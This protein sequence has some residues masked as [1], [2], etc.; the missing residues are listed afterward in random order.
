MATVDEVDTTSAVK[1]FLERDTVVSRTEED[2]D[3]GEEVTAI[4]EAAA[5]SFLL[6]PQSALT[7]VLMAKNQLQQIVSKDIELLDFIDRAINDVDNPDIQISDL[8]DL[9]EASTALV[10]I[11]RI[12]SFQSDTKAFTRYND[13]INR[14]LDQQLA[15]SLKRR[16]RGEFERSGLEARQDLSNGL[17]LFGSTHEVLIEVLTNLVSS[18]DNFRSVDLTKLVSQKTV[19]RV[20]TS[21]QKVQ[22]GFQKNSIS[23]TSAA[24]ELMAGAASLQSISKERDVYDP[25]LETGVFPAGRDIRISSEPTAA[26]AITP[27]D[28][29][30][31]SGLSI[32]ALHFKVDEIGSNPFTGN[33]GYFVDS[34]Y[35]QSDVFSGDTITL[36]GGPL[37]LYLHIEGGGVPEFEFDL[38]TYG[39]SVS[40]ITLSIDLLIALLPDAQVALGTTFDGRHYFIIVA[41]NPAVTQII[42][43]ESGQG[44]VSGGGTLT[45]A[46]P[47]GHAS[48]HFGANQTS[49]SGAFVTREALVRDFNLNAGNRLVA[50]LIDIPDVGPGVKVSSLSTNPDSSIRF[51]TTTPVVYGFPYTLNTAQP[52]AFLLTENDQNIDPQSVGVF[53]GSRIFMIDDF[54]G[55]RSGAFI[56]TAIDG[57]R[58]IC[59]GVLARGKN[60]P[61]KV[62][63][64][65]VASVQDLLLHST[66]FVS[67]FNN[68]V[69]DLQ[70]VTAPLLSPQPTPA[71]IA[72]AKKVVAAIKTKLTNEDAD[73]LLD[74]LQTI[75]VRDDQSDFA[76]T[77]KTILTALEERG[78]DKA[79]DLL[80]SGKFSD[81]FAL[82]TESASK[83][84]QFLRAVEVVMTSS[85]KT[86]TLES[87]MEDVRPSGTVP[88][89]TL[90][91]L[92]SSTEDT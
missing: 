83:S 51:L 11:D 77:A 75:V 46:D 81:F 24:I 35:V 13:A 10:E 47:S 42:V 69:R 28:T 20:R 12:G 54:D 87:E 66:S 6:S 88:D 39:G 57:N 80:K 7:L 34:V 8:S 64:P 32:A 58:I 60:K 55:Q 78:L 65:A 27:L 73:G 86:T 52:Q 48:L 2:Y 25:T 22:R 26:F 16:R 15:K 76:Q 1:K 72:D 61:V 40:A 90:A 70:R 49:V 44:S 74:V 19:S 92:E 29:Y 33:F 31:I 50:T 68:D 23:K 5:I 59:D 14:F 43:K 89:G 53:V 38:S 45:P 84:G 21:L 62:L 82:G 17:S 3:Q 37:K 67:S 4:L 91:T 56:V 63:A 71:Q 30:S 41:I 9:T 85:L 18:V 79:T 36:P